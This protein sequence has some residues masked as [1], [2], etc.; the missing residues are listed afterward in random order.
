MVNVER[1]V[2]E[3]YR[4]T[5]LLLLH[6][7]NDRIALPLLD[8]DYSFIE[9]ILRLANDERRQQILLQLRNLRSSALP[10]FK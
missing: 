3:R 4:R 1:L 5:Y 7:S 8:D 6:P 10:A 9:E 2:G